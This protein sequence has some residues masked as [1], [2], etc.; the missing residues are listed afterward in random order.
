MRINAQLL[1]SKAKG[2]L[3]ATEYLD[4][5]NLEIVAIEKFSTCPK[6][7]SLILR[8]NDIFEVANLEHCTQLWRLDLGNN[9]IKSLDGLSRFVALGTLNLANN[10][11]TWH[12]LGKIRHVHVLNLSLHGNPQLEKD[13]YYRIHVIDCLPHVWMLDGRLVTSAERLQVK[14][15]FQDSALTE[16]PIRHKLAK[17]WFVPSNLKKIE[18]NGVFGEKATHVMR[19]F[20]TNGAHNIETDRRRLKYVAYNIQ[21]DLV[22]DKKYTNREYQVLKYRQAFLED[23]LEIRPTDLE[24]CNM[25]LLLLVTSLEFVLPTHLVKET[26]DTA[27][28]SK[29]G[30]VYTMDLFLLPRDVRCH[31]V[32]VLLAAVK[33]DKDDREDGGLYDKLYLCLFYTISELMKLSQSTSTKQTAIKSKLNTLYSDYKCLLASEVIQLL[34]IVPA[35]F[36]YISKDIGVM[37]LIMTGTGDTL[38]AEKIAR[39]SSVVEDKGGEL[40]RLYEDQ[41]E[42]LLQKV[43]EQCLNL[44]NRTQKIP[45]S[46]EVIN[47]MK[48]LPMKRPLSALELA[49]FHSKGVTSPHK[50]APR[51]MS[52]RRPSDRGRKRFPRL[53]D[54]L[55]L[56][57]QTLGKIVSL[58]QPFVALVSM[59]S[60]PV[61]NG[62]M[63]S[64][65]KHSDDHYTYINMDH[66]GWDLDLGVWKPKGAIGD[67]VMH[68]DARLTM[69]NVEDLQKDLERKANMDDNTIRPNSPN[70]NTPTPGPGQEAPLL[71]SPR[72]PPTTPEK[73]PRPKEVQET[74]RPVS[75]LLKEKLDLKLDLSRRVLST[76]DTDFPR[77]G[78]VDQ[79]RDGE[80]VAMDQTE[81]GQSGRDG[82]GQPRT[83]RPVH[84]DVTLATGAMPV[85]ETAQQVP[86][87]PAQD[88][89]QAPSQ[90]PPH[91][92]VVSETATPS[93]PSSNTAPSVVTAVGGVTGIPGVH[94]CIQCAMEAA[95]LAKGEKRPVGHTHPVQGTGENK[96]NHMTNG[97][98]NG[99]HHVMVE[100]PHTSAGHH[101]ELQLSIPGDTSLDTSH[102]SDTSRTTPTGHRSNARHHPSPRFGP[103]AGKKVA[104][105]RARPFSAVD[106]YRYIVAHPIRPSENA[107]NSSYQQQRTEAWKQSVQARAQQNKEA[108]EETIPPPVITVQMAVVQ[109]DNEDTVGNWSPP[110]ARPS[111]P[112]MKNKTVS[113]PGSAVLNLST[114]NH[115]LAGG[116]DVYWEN[117][118]RRPMSGH[119]PGWKEGLP[120]NMQRPRS[121]VASRTWS[122]RSKTPTPVTPSSL[123]YESVM[124][125][126]QNPWSLPELTDLSDYPSPTHQYSQ[127]RALGTPTHGT[128]FYNPPAPDTVY[129]TP[130]SS[131]RS[132]SPKVIYSGMHCIFESPENDIDAST[133]TQIYT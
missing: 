132:R 16:H 31:V 69:H 68:F 97:H 88:Q 34:C 133:D 25:L 64:K 79:Q 57:P 14:H 54:I 62:A 23:L 49:D 22:I 15:F 6:L 105:A 5:S 45:S 124:Q 11:L 90:A 66:L 130:P 126:Y 13:P 121:A 72:H 38:I 65:L 7:H 85:Q 123:M 24:R 122:R 101:I 99:H 73:G 77:H 118:K 53:G 116:R 18:V 111:S 92:P 108:N 128:D 51:I 129:R 67:S 20:P 100:R 86:Q 48:A 113:R 26:L 82:E 87:T 95:A 33:I 127:P 39:V 74:P 114:G 120:D 83:R 93:Q 103:F 8:G 56:G 19:R 81:E 52:A 37:N 109:P 125:G 21:E 46:D 107:Y 84:I 104:T 80:P 102:S 115:W 42:L 76:R 9:C 10:A 55:L 60:V 4:L 63:E 110:P 27:K 119:V 1:R 96:E 59:D 75:S 47:S 50:D 131:P 41:A 40:K 58:P 29:L 61:A 89:S 94:D 17:E 91:A 2:P 35:F 78:G 36:E 30:K 106:A 70:W 112:A 71:Y 3:Q 28:L 117:A 98:H 44:S 32:C 43:Q 12:E